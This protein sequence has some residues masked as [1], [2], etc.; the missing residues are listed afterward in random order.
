[1]RRFPIALTYLLCCAA[2]VVAQQPAPAALQIE[3]G[4]PAELKGVKKIFIDTGMDMKNRERM[5][6]EFSKAKLAD[7][8][9]LDSPE[10]A[11]VLLLFNAD[12][13]TY[14]AGMTTNPSPGAGWPSTS[15]PRYSTTD[16]GVGIVV[17]PKGENRARLLMQ[18][19]KSAYYR[20]D[21]WPSVSFVRE[22]VK[23]Y[24]KANGI[25]K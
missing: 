15:T 25:K 16:T 22:F 4:S 19:E 24:R 2:F 10:G 8:V 5:L 12:R 14:F 9:L 1:M 20:W 6:K 11:E 18:V 23:E 17:I 21:K 7:L 13:N 3:Y